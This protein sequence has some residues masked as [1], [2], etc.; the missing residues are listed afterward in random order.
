M[1]RFAWGVGPP[2]SQQHQINMTK[3]RNL[4]GDE[5]HFG[6]IHIALQNHGPSR[7]SRVKHVVPPT[8]WPSTAAGCRWLGSCARHWSLEQIPQVTKASQWRL[9]T[10]WPCPV[11]SPGGSSGV[12]LDMKPSWN[13]VF[14]WPSEGTRGLSSGTRTSGASRACI[15]NRL[16]SGL[17]NWCVPCTHRFHFW[18]RTVTLWRRGRGIHEWNEREA[19][20]P[21]SGTPKRL[22]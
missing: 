5:T 9:G 17:A 11:R 7:P 2:G 12:A 22:V 10:Q 20:N 19:P 15:W 16:L 1:L 6:N 14:L 21:Q 13:P 4:W 18:G 3:T 8:A